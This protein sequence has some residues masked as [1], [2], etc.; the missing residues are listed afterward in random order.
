MPYH[1]PDG[2]GYFH[3][4]IAPCIDYMLAMHKT[5]VLIGLFILAPYVQSYGAMDLPATQNTL[6]AQPR[7][8]IGVILPLSGKWK[9]VGHKMLKG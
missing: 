6:A 5:L 9:S 3:L 1:E 8:A 2:Q 4:T 7:K